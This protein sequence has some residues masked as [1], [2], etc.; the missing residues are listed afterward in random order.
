M[1]RKKSNQLTDV[2]QRIL[3]VLWKEGEASVKDIAQALSEEKPTAYTTAQTMCKILEEKGYAEYRKE[4]RAFIYRA[5][6]SQKEARQGALTSL[7]NRF[8]GSSPELL[9]Q[10]LMEE[11]NINLDDLQSLQDQIDKED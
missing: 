9:A 11:S 6:I 3:E 5:K 1:A 4:G 2:E 10:H 8:F 7:L